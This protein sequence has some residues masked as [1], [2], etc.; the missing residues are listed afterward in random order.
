MPSV[1]GEWL[2]GLLL[3]VLYVAAIVAMRQKGAF[4]DEVDH[5][6]QISLFARGDWRVLPGITTI[7]GYHL[8]VAVILR[9]T[10]SSLDAARLVNAGFG[11][12]AIAGFH[13]LRRRLWLGTETLATAQLIVLPILVPL[14]FVVYTDVLALA[15][16]L[17][18]AWA[19]VTRR[20]A[21][22]ALLLTLLVGVRQHEVLWA[23]LFGLF[24]ITA[25]PARTGLRYGWRALPSLLPYALPLVCF[26]LFWWWN[27]TVSLSRSQAG[28]HPDL[29]LHAGNP[30]L[31]LLVAGV[32]LPLHVVCG[33]REF[34]AAVRRSPWLGAIPFLLAAGFWFGFRPDNPYNTALPAYYLHNLIPALIDGDQKAR[35]LAAVVAAIAACGLAPTRLRPDGARWF[36]PFAL[37]FLAASWL[38]ELRYVLVPFVLWLALREHRGR[39]IEHATL[40]LWLVLAVCMMF[41]TVTHRFFL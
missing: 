26:G 40:A 34:A 18:A 8:L 28:L 9:V 17:W 21:L 22:A 15:L 31:A 38:V 3:G 4:T 32:L 30:C 36:Y 14:F 23:G 19:N 29:S 11:L 10:E 16:L 33:L 7:P 27:G 35:A 6:A 13:A 1:P 2:L 24:A 5:Y 39:A 20:H 25:A 37:L 12:I 41:A